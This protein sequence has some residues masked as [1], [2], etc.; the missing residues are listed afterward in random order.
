MFS[1]I[2]LPEAM[3][4]FAISDPSW[5]YMCGW[6]GRRYDRNRIEAMYRR[7]FPELVERESVSA[8]KEGAI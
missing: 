8:K 1:R 7:W 4:R 3:H 2:P 6:G 5:M